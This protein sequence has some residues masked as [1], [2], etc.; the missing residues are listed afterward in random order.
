MSVKIIRFD[1]GITNLYLVALAVV[2]VAAAWFF[3]KWNLANMIASAMNTELPEAR[4][5]AD[6]LVQMSPDDPQTHLAAARIFEQT[7]DAGDLTRSVAEYKAAT[8]LSPNNYLLWLELGK[9]RDGSG[10]V[11]SAED[12]FRRA[13]ELAPN[14][15]A[16]QWAYGNSL[17]RHGKPDEG[18]A[19]IAKAAAANRDYSNPAVATA[20]QI[21]DGDVSQVRKI[22]GDTPETNAALAS[23]LAA[24]TKFDD[25]GEAWS[26]L[27][28]ED[29][30][31]K[32]KATG[33]KLIEQFAAA[34]KYQ[35]AARVT[36]DLAPDGGEKPVV[37]EI[38]NGGFENSIK[39][40]GAGIFEWQIADGPAPQIGL[41]EGERHAGKY[42][43]FISFNSNEP[44]AF[45]NVTQTVAVAPGAAYEF[46][47]FYRSDLKTLAVLKWE[48]ADAVTGTAIASTPAIISAADWTS[49]KAKFTVPA[50]SD[51]VIIRLIRE[52]CAGATCA[53]GGKLSFDDLSIK[54]L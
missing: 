23:V 47:A 22:L 4:L 30:R 1:R 45:R 15:A 49:L 14:Y 5:V 2:C 37:G 21:F 36:A 8:D 13:L 38:S 6:P 7:F 26:K 9:A 33:D 42:S 11:S 51:G 29:K 20:M 32:Y 19:L 54:R 40:R 48:I 24:Q 46:E 34:K 28:A 41:T 44:A 31:T 50:T 18:F 43:L 35:L 25:A 3:M 17:I 16:V 27:A 39:L 52:G 10:D 12:A 53:A